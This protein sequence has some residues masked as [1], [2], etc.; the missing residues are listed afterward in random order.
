MEFHE[1]TISSQYTGGLDKAAGVPMRQDL[2]ESKWRRML[3]AIVMLLV[4]VGQRRF[5]CGKRWFCLLP[6]DALTPQAPGT[7]GKRRPYELL[8][9]D[10]YLLTTCLVLLLYMNLGSREGFN[11]A[12]YIRSQVSTHGCSKEPQYCNPRI[13]L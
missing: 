5:G 13:D 3:P 4:I 6:R 12:I 9:H 11:H 7:N 2:F 1:L 8:V 10:M